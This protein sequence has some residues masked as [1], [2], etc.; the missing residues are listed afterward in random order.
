MI[1]IHTSPS[2]ENQITIYILNTHCLSHRQVKTFT[3]FGVLKRCAISFYTILGIAFRKSSYTLIYRLSMGCHTVSPA[4]VWVRIP[5]PQTW[6]RGVAQCPWGGIPGSVRILG[7]VTQFWQNIIWQKICIIE[8]VLENCF[9]TPYW[10]FVSEGG[11]VNS[12]WKWR[13]VIMSPAHNP[14][15]LQ[16]PILLHSI[17]LADI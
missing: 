2:G 13:P 15:L 3:S 5:G 14:L 9:H 16:L 17:T 6:V 10:H 8:Q 11:S 7:Q 12:S 1:R 4:P